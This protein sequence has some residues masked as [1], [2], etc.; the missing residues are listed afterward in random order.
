M[1]G[2]EE[3]KLWENERI[4]YHKGLAISR[5][6]RTLGGERLNNINET[7][8]AFF[9]SPILNSPYEEPSRYWE[10]DEDGKTWDM[11]FR[12][13]ATKVVAT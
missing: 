3:G 4:A 7:K 11:I 8:G 6:S 9:D 5:Y 12:E 1:R 13:D 2:E 10:L